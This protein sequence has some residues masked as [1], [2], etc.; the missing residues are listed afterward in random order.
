MNITRAGVFQT[1]FEKVMIYNPPPTK[2]NDGDASPSTCTLKNSTGERV[3]REL[4]FGNH[5]KSLVELGRCSNCFTALLCQLHPAY[6][7]T[8]RN[9]DVILDCLR[10]SS[11]SSTSEEKPKLTL[12]RHRIP[13]GL[14]RVF[15][16]TDASEALARATNLTY[17]RFEGGM[18]VFRDQTGAE[19]KVENLSM[20]RDCNQLKTLTLDNCPIRNVKLPLLQTVESVSL[21]NC[22]KLTEVD[23]SRCCGLKHI[24]LSGCAN[25]EQISFGGCPKLETVTFPAKLRKLEELKHAECPA[26]KDET[27]QRCQ[28]LRREIID[29][30]YNEDED[31]Y[32]RA[33]EFEFVNDPDDPTLEEELISGEELAA[34]EKAEDDASEALRAASPSVPPNLFSQEN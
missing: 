32:E 8:A 18:C 7:K 2:Q 12:D 14:Q 23:F 17:R 34:E 25:L 26:L 19:I 4:S 16:M 15:G 6:R 31:E 29:R 13:A 21:K 27:T 30:R 24:N 28:A 22:S 10:G 33:N 9:Y 20:L 5:L 3:F 11:G 1:A